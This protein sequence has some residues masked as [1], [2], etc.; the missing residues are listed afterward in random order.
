MLKVSSSAL[1]RVV[2]GSVAVILGPW[3]KQEVAE[4]TGER[5]KNEIFLQITLVFDPAS[6]NNLPDEPILDVRGLTK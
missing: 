3:I 1:R 2:L 4:F 6:R 5:I